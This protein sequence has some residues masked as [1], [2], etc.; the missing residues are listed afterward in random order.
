VTTNSLLRFS[1]DL[2][3]S[4]E[5][6]LKSSFLFSSTRRKFC[7][8]PRIAT[9][10]P[11]RLRTS[12]PHLSRVMLFRLS[13]RYRSYTKSSRVADLYCV[14]TN[15]INT[16]FAYSSKVFAVPGFNIW[17]IAAPSSIMHVSSGAYVLGDIISSKHCRKS[18]FVPVRRFPVWDKDGGYSWFSCRKRSSRFPSHVWQAM[19]VKTGQQLHIILQR[20][21]FLLDFWFGF[22]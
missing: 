20:G 5:R 18:L 9:D 22:C 7:H 17:T 11:T 10:G 13:G 19:H 15:G 16:S 1:N 12:F 2:I 21:Y 6:K 8:C 3:N 14:R 4:V